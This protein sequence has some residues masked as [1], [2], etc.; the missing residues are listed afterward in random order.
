M[1]ITTPEYVHSKIYLT[2]LHYI[3]VYYCGI[4]IHSYEEMII[5]YHLHIFLI[6]YYCVV[7]NNP[8]YNLNVRQ[9]LLSCFC[10]CFFLETMCPEC[11][12]MQMLGKLVVLHNTLR[13]IAHAIHL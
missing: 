4:F 1:V 3:Y 12:A 6:I 2:L 5:L 10:A 13:I 9:R 7:I 8:L 11:K